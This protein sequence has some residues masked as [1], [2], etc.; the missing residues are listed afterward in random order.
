MRLLHFLKEFFLRSFFIVPIMFA[1]G[2]TAHDLVVPALVPALVP[3]TQVPYMQAPPL[4]IVRGGGRTGADVGGVANVEGVAGR[5]YRN[6]RGMSQIEV[7]LPTSKL[8]C[9]NITYKDGGAS[10]GGTVVLLTVPTNYGQVSAA[11]IR[12]LNPSCAVS[13]TRSIPRRARSWPSVDLTTGVCLC[14]RS[15]GPWTDCTTKH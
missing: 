2:A 8:K 7:G 9:A 1:T 11:R 6:T 12:N 5:N 10:T 3:A 14:T 15:S 4:P 13:T